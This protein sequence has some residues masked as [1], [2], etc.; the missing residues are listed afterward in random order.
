MET[1]EL[2]LRYGTL[3]GRLV[4]WHLDAFRVEWAGAAWRAGNGRGAVVFRV[5]LTGEVEAMAFEAIPGETWEL[6][7]RTPTP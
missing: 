4:H 2:L 5:G 7:R 6:A 1:G 3:A